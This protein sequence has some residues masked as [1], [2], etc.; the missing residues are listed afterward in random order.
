VI[1]SKDSPCLTRTIHN[2]H[3]VLT[4]LC[5]QR[6]TVDTIDNASRSELD[7]VVIYLEDRD[8]E[9]NPELRN[10]FADLLDDGELGRSVEDSASGTL[11]DQ[12][13]TRALRHYCK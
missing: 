3:F 12:P 7:G 2:L 4:F 10:L 9:E 1:D 5:R 8:L 6:V 13:K 11:A